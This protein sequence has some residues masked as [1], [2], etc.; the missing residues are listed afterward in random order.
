MTNT[1]FDSTRDT[2]VRVADGAAEIMGDHIRYNDSGQ[3]ISRHDFNFETALNGSNCQ[4]LRIIDAGVGP[5]PSSNASTVISIR[6]GR[7]YDAAVIELIGDATKWTI[8]SATNYWGKTDILRREGGPTI[9]LEDIEALYTV[10]P[11][12]PPHHGL[13]NRRDAWLSGRIPHI[14]DVIGR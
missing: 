4:H 6:G 9:L 10:D 1:Q 13:E 3:R 5:A 8:E 12:D 11:N 14:C 7:D 2:V